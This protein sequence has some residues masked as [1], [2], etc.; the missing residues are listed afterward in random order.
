LTSRPLLPRSKAVTIVLGMK[1][2]QGVILAADTQE[3]YTQSHKVNRPKLVYKADTNL[4]GTPIVFSVAGAGVGPWIDKLTTAMWESVQDATSL[5][6]ACV[7]LEETVIKQYH[8]FRGLLS[9]DPTADLIYA[10]GCPGGVRLFYAYGPI[11]NEERVRASGSGQPIADFLLRNFTDSLHITNAM[12]LAIYV[13]MSAK[14]HADGCGGETQVAI[15]HRDGFGAELT[16]EQI[17]ASEKILDAAAGYGDM[18]LMLAANPIIDESG[19]KAASK[20]LLSGV[21][22]ELSGLAAVSGMQDLLDKIKKA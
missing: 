1:T 22:R 9:F 13:L 6:D 12:A 11:V 15:I 18:M 2:P 17:G 5:D 14:R 19:L 7:N 4:S 3:T 10:I 8:D 20:S 21:T 16:A